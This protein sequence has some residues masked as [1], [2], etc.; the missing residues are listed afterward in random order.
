[1]AGSTTTLVIVTNASG[2]E[3]TVNHA[4]S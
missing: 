1:L 2:Y 3:L 4:P